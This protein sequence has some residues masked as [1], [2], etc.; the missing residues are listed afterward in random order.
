MA[1]V[2]DVDLVRSI[3]SYFSQVGWTPPGLF[4]SLCLTEPEKAQQLYFSLEFRM[5]PTYT[6]SYKTQARAYLRN[7]F[8]YV[9]NL[10]EV[11]PRPKRRIE[12]DIDSSTFSSGPLSIGQEPDFEIVPLPVGPAGP[13]G[14][15]GP[16]GP[17][18]YPIYDITTNPI[19]IVSLNNLDSGIYELHLEVKIVTNPSSSRLELSFFDGSTEISLTQ[20][21]TKIIEYTSNT[22]ITTNS[23]I[24]SRL[25]ENDIVTDDMVGYVITIMFESPGNFFYTGQGTLRTSTSLFSLLVSGGTRSNF[26]INSFVILLSSG[27]FSGRIM[28]MKIA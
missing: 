22:I 15:P 4:S 19:G 6:L 25:T 8:R 26:T 24:R 18:I 3:D 23:L 20:H 5:P 2:S 11:T 13:P 27:T 12:S 28:L 21:T 17:G 9:S 10:E 7:L 16:V 14:A 1:A